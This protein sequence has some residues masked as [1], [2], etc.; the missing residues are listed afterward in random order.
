MTMGICPIN[1]I[2]N[3]WTTLLGQEFITGQI[4]MVRGSG[5]DFT[6]SNHG[7]MSGALASFQY[8]TTSRY[9][10]ATTLS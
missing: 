1:K 5:M 9:H 4:P 10:S 2:Y 8:T 6:L 3:A 7:E